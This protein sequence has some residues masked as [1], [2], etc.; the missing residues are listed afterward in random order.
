MTFLSSLKRLITFHQFS[1]NEKW[2]GKNTKRNENE[3]CV[4]ELKLKWANWKA[5]FK[6]RS[7]NSIGRFS[8]SIRFYSL[9]ANGVH[10]GHHRWIIEKKNERQERYKRKAIFNFRNRRWHVFENWSKGHVNAERIQWYQPWHKRNAFN[11]TWTLPVWKYICGKRTYIFDERIA[12]IWKKKN[13][14][15]H[16]KCE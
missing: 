16:F 15:H 5:I 4:R 9:D 8:V 7:L 10:I 12:A 14:P 6:C 3:Y 13:R 11:L 2:N 1:V